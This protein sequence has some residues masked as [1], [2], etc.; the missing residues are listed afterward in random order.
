MALTGIP[1]IDRLLDGSNPAPIAAGDP[2][3]AAVGVIQDLLTGHGCRNLP[4]LTDPNLGVFGKRTTQALRSI[5][6]RDAVD[7]AA[8]R[9][10]VDKDAVTPIAS[11]G[12][13]AL[14]L[15]MEFS[16]M[17]R[18]LS[19]TS[20]FETRRFFSKC[21]RNTDKQGLSFGLIQWAQKPG[22]LREILEAFRAEQP[23]KFASIFVD[24]G[25][26]IAHVSKP[27]GGVNDAGSTLD[28]DFDLIQGLWLAR[29]EQ[30]GRDRDLERV[31]LNCAAT[32]FLRSYKALRAYAT[33]VT[34]ERGVAFMLDL[35]NQHGDGGGRSIYR[36]VAAGGAASEPDLLKAMQEESVARIR[37][38]YGEGNETIGAIERRGFFRTA[39]LLLDNPFEP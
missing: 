7:Q 6:G 39:P 35:V 22:R 18:V 12:Y 4:G 13:I 23:A 27:K 9:T 28:P 29:F 31:Q 15:G 21:K 11:R 24:G 20:H 10:L 34:S 19:F 16:P 26:L 32:A 25:G 33:G 38:Q 1:R 36:K 5:C 30:A 14:V 17:L 3:R 37:R 8:L 2:D